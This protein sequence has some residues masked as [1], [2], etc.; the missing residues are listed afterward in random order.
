MSAMLAVLTTV[1]PAE[2]IKMLSS[3]AML[4]IAVYKAAKAG[5]R[6]G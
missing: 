5:K 2:A 1:P 3:G 4:S 6:R